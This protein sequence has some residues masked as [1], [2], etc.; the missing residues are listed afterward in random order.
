MKTAF[1]TLLLITLFAGPTLCFLAVCPAQAAGHDCCPDEQAPPQQAMAF[2][3]FDIL[4]ESTVAIKIDKTAA[5]LAIAGPI[6]VTTPVAAEQTGHAGYTVIAN[7]RN[8]HEL[9]RV[10]RI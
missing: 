7:G 6:A 2:C 9:N 3:P 1:A 8:L 10:L 4:T 5:G